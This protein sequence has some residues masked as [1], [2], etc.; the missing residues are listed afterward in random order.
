[1]IEVPA[2]SP[3]VGIINPVKGA[4]VEGVAS[5]LLWGYAADCYG[6]HL[7]DEALVW[8]VN[9]KV[10][11]TGHTMPMPVSRKKRSQYRVELVAKD[12]HGSVRATVN[13]RARGKGVSQG[14]RS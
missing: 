4:M 3:Q 9:R 13:V 12:E 10:I 5:L 6:R 7:P 1:M 2:R 14:S 8:R 11:G